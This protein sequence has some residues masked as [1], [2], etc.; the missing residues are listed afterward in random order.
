MI[1]QAT[2]AQR[3]LT[4]DDYRAFRRDGFLVVR[5]LVASHE[6]AELRA[7]TEDIMHGRLP[8]QRDGTVAAPPADASPLERALHLVRIHMLHR[9]LEL[10]ERYLLHPRVLDVLQALIGPDVLALQTMLILKPPG[11]EGQGWHQDS[12]YIPTEPDSLCGAWIAIDDCDEYNGAMW[13]ARGSQIE[14]SYPSRGHGH[15]EKMLADIGFAEHT[16][17][18]DDAVNQL[19]PVADRYPQVLVTAKAGD[20]VFFGGHV[21][22]R[23]KPNRS[24]RFRRA[25]VSHYCNARAYTA[26][27]A[28]GPAGDPHA[29]STVDPVTGATN[30]SHILARGD[31]HLAY[32]LPKFGSDCAALADAQERRRQREFCAAD[33]GAAPV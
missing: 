13:F 11:R 31:T 9:Q 18:M 22:H 29:S 33:P 12:Y 16:S 20:V 30:G 19:A 8:E 32:A 24:D 6:I 26:W 4:V 21:L 5:G 28:D 2:A 3:L 15:G 14:P 1:V 23:S 10:H 17:D 7:H 27:G 25:F